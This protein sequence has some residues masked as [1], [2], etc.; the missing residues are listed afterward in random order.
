MNGIRIDTTLVADDGNETIFKLLVNKQAEDVVLF[1]FNPQGPQH[2]KV[3]EIKA[4]CAGLIT[5]MQQLQDEIGS[6][7]PA[8]YRAAA[9]AITEMEGAQMRLVKALFAK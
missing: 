9:I 5:I 1:S 8:K 3:Q 2:A 4:L 7:D 6:A